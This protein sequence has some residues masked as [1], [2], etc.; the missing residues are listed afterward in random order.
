MRG[1]CDRCA[2]VAAARIYVP[3]GALL[4]L[5]RHHGRQHA[6]VLLSKGAVIVG[7]LSFAPAGPRPVLGNTPTPGTHQSSR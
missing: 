7:E 5:C 6:D 1:S 3:G 4:M 2:A